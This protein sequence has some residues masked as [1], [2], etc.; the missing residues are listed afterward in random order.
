MAYEHFILLVQKMEKLEKSKEHGEDP[1]KTTKEKL[2][3]I[4]LDVASKLVKKEKL[5]NMERIKLG[6]YTN[7]LCEKTELTDEECIFLGKL[8][9]RVGYEWISLQI[10][11]ITDNQAKELWKFKMLSLHKLTSITDE[12]AKNLSKVESL[13]INRKILTQKQKEILRR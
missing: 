4:Q 3:E 2:E 12:Q 13:D 9:Q 8:S 1:I 6:E 7:K 11:K 10:K 5:S